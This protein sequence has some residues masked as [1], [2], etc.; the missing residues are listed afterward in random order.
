MPDPIQG[1][2][3]T[4]PVGVATTGQAGSAT[5]NAPASPPAVPAADSADVGKTEGLLA[6]IVQAAAE[7]PSIDQARIDA[8]RQA[9][10]DGSYQTDPHE[11]ARKLLEIESGLDP[12]GAGS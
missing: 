8:L 5:A 2:G 3:T 9:I 6:A 1:V 4:N 12:A 11:I 10:A 7:L